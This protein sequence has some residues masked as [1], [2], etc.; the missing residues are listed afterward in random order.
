MKNSP[1]S[2]PFFTYQI[3]V[4]ICGLIQNWTLVEPVAEVCSA[5]FG[6]VHSDLRKVR[7]QRLWL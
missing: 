2:G 4:E 1:K 7:F 3:R 6:A 5:D